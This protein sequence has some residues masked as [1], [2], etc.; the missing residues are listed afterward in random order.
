MIASQPSMT[1]AHANQYTRGCESQTGMCKVIDA[2]P[3]RKKKNYSDK[4]MSYK[5]KLNSKL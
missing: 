4:F 5:C 3:V 2:V 1:A